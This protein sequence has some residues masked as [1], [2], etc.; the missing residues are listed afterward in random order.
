MNK[1]K[2]IF[3]HPDIVKEKVNDFKEDTSYNN[4][5]TKSVSIPKVKEISFVLKVKN[6]EVKK[7]R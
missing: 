3:G 6:D 7:I 4:F 5:N 1:T 2:E